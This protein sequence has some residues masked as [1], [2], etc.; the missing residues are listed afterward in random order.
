MG[1][2]KN[3]ENVRPAG[4]PAPKTKPKKVGNK[5]KRNVASIIGLKAASRRSIA[6][7]AVQVSISDNHLCFN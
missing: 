6:Y 2:D 7:A 5:T 4:T 3:I 1:K